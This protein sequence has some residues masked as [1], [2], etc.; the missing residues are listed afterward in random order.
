MVH[1]TATL[2][3]TINTVNELPPVFIPP[4]SPTSPYYVLTV[5]E[6]QPPLSYITT[7]VAI[8]PDNDIVTYMLTGNNTSNF[9][10]APQT[11]E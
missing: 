5:P 10:L 3:V 2:I 1:C 8:D 9:S 6:R 7:M 11:G 4:W